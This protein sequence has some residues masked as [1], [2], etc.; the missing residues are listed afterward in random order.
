MI[1]A[2]NYPSK[3]SPMNRT[4][5]PISISFP[6]HSPVKRGT[7]KEQLHC[8]ETLLH[9]AARRDEVCTGGNFEQGGKLGLGVTTAQY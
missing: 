8:M 5:A 1:E 9:S 7:G 2:S 3:V 6:C 4:A